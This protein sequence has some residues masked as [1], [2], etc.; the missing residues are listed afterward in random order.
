MRWAMHKVASK[1]FTPMTTPDLVRTG[2]I[3]ACGFQSRGE[4]S[5]IYDIEGTD[6]SLVGTA[7]L[8]LA[9]YYMNTIVS[10]AVIVTVACHVVVL[11]AYCVGVLFTRSCPS[12]WWHS[13][14]VSAARLVQEA[15]KAVDCT[16]C[17]SSPRWKCS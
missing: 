3:D 8:P 4:H 17:T 14:I 7:E 5:Q 15:S 13:V 11:M 1:G 2:V 16:V 9:G 12:R 10:E 6:L